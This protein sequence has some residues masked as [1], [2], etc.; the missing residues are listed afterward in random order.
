M[1]LNKALLVPNLEIFVFSQNF[2]IRQIR[3]DW[4]Q[5]QQHYFQIATQKYPNKVFFPKCKDFYF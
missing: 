5:I 3:G 4:F 2:A 1:Y